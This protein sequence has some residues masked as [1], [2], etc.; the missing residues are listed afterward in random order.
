MSGDIKE[1]YIYIYIYI[2]R[3]WDIYL[4]GQRGLI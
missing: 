2:Y 1:I 3:E 4:E